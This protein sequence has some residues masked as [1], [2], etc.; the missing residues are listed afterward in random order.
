MSSGITR[1][2]A[3]YR[4]KLDNSNLR[5]KVSGI[6]AKDYPTVF[7]CPNDSPNNLVVR[8]SKGNG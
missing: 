1:L 6:K 8:V 4:T 3:L 2:I 7:S 5:I